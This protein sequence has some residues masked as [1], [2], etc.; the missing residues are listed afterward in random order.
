[1]FVSD[2]GWSDINGWWHLYQVSITPGQW[3]SLPSAWLQLHSVTRLQ[4]WQCAWTWTFL[5]T[6]TSQTMAETQQQNYNCLHH[7]KHDNCQRLVNNTQT[8]AQWREKRNN[9]VFHCVTWAMRLWLWHGQWS[10]LLLEQCMIVELWVLI[11]KQ[12]RIV[13]CGGAEICHADNSSSL[14]WSMIAMQCSLL[15]TLSITSLVVMTRIK[16]TWQH[17]LWTLLCGAGKCR[18]KLIAPHNRESEPMTEND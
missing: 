15:M 7:T 9:F 3:S 16:Q 1:M 5:R 4:W 18:Q 6:L 8:S 17:T 13:M 10:L 12:S 2:H 14:C 11:I